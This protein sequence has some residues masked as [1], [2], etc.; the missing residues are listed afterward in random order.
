MFNP[1]YHPK[2]Q[3]WFNAHLLPAPSWSHKRLAAVSGVSCQLLVLT[4]VGLESMEEDYETEVF[5]CPP[6]IG[7]VIRWHLALRTCQ[8]LKATSLSLGHFCGF[9][10]C[11][12]AGPPGC[13]SYDSGRSLFSKCCW[14]ISAQQ[15]PGLLMVQ[16]HHT[17]AVGVQVPFPDG[18]LGSDIKWLKASS[19][20]RVVHIW[21]MGEI[22]TF[23]A[24]FFFSAWCDWN[25]CSPF[26]EG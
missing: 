5:P 23:E 15:D 16:S 10:S 6:W 21:S 18:P 9:I 11:I 20:S 22:S 1:N 7:T 17:L 2:L 4:T 19:L 3:T 25:E 26:K 13:N 14:L 12:P 24:S 8:M